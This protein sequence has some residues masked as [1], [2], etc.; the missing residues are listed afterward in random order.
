MP[1]VR[2]VLQRFIE[3]PG[4]VT[5]RI[6]REIV[7]EA[8]RLLAPMAARALT[9]ERLIRRFGE[10]SIDTLWRKL[11][12]QPFPFL[13]D[14]KSAAQIDEAIPG[15]RARI[16]AAADR[17]LSR[18]IDLLGTGPVDLG[19]P[20]QWLTDLKTGD[21]W[22][23]GFCRHIEY[24]NSGRPSDVK[25]P[26]E[27][28]RLQWMIPVGQAYLL[29]GDDRYA[30][31]ARD[32]FQEWIEGN[33]HAWTVNW[34][35]TME[36]ALRILT[37]IWFFHVLHGAEAWRDAEFRGAF[38]TALHLHG[39]FVERH[40]ER[41]HI[42]GNHYTADAA[43]MVA[44][45]LF[46]RGDRDA[47][48]WAASGWDIL[49]SEIALQVHGDGVDFEASSAYHRLVAELFLLPARYRLARGLDVAK[50]YAQRLLAMGA[51]A[52]HYSRPDGTSPNWGDADDGRALP[53]GMQPL[54]DHRY[55]APLIGL[56]LDDGTLAGQ[57]P[58]SADQGELFWAG[59]VPAAV[60]ADPPV[61]RAFPDGGVYIL[62]G[63]QSHIFVDCGPVGL[64]GLGGHGHNDALSFDAWLAGSPLIIDPGSFVYT[65]DFAAR[66]LFR[67]TARHNTP[68]VDGAE[69]NRL[70]A[71]DNLW[72]LH[73][74]ARCEVLR[75]DPQAERGLF[76]G[77]H[78]G[79]ERLAE[80]VSVTRCL[81]VDFVAERLVVEDRLDGRGRHDISI[82][83]HFAPGVEINAVGEGAVQASSA[84]ASFAIQ[85]T[86]DT[87]ITTTIEDYEASPSYG[88]KHWAQRL[89]ARAEAADVPA[90]ITFTVERMG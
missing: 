47:D 90:S 48:R 26:W 70:V 15:V 13:T 64:A 40:I 24:V 38:L 82:P 34:S 1:S 79:Y 31:F 68:Q 19:T 80:P 85:V 18:Q 29:T 61:S 77:R 22:P 4:Y 76:E 28:S 3:Q 12:A 46:F 43:G 36:P 35:C 23:R 71:P 33:P 72:Q 81:T 42:N 84:T 52:A 14:Q 88:V 11:A 60:R 75:F 21:T 32:I 25:V 53:L 65:A 56:S 74:D 51:F 55:L 2:R 6:G 17:A 5:R 57:G 62:R 20:A 37:W 58:R 69:I 50:P 27:V 10:A 73:E 16:I 63:G 41:A 49:Q 78:H 9:P 89:V 54:G 87:E 66:N 7:M 67:S 83:V 59:C 45:G 8:D 39:R 86:A 30:A 44:A